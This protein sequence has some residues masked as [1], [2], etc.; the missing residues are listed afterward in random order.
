MRFKSIMNKKQLI[1]WLLANGFTKE[2]EKE[3]EDK[4]K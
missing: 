1:K 4:N 2:S 3:K